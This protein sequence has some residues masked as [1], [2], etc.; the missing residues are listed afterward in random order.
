MQT[1]KDMIV[2]VCLTAFCYSIELHSSALIAD[3]AVEQSKLSGN[4]LCSICD[5]ELEAEIMK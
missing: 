4:I 5:V 2:Q 3:A 1:V